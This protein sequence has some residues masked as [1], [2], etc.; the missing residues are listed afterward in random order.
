[1]PGDFGV[2]IEG[3]RDLW[4]ALAGIQQDLGDLGADF[5][6]YDSVLGAAAVKHQLS[7][8]AGNW[9]KSRQRINGELEALAKMADGAAAQYAATETDISRSFSSGDPRSAGGN[10]GG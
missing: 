4:R 7:D 6:Q 10:S 9:K 5:G 2:D 3:L 8:V 1:V